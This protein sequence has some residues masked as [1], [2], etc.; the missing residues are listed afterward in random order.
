M[1]WGLSIVRSA[2]IVPEIVAHQ[3][4][5]PTYTQGINQF[6]QFIQ[7]VNQRCLHRMRRPPG[8][9]HNQTWPYFVSKVEATTKNLHLLNSTPSTTEWKGGRFPSTRQ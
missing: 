4:P 6:P 2:C 8:Q 3:T 1:R 5:Y 9:I 7:Q